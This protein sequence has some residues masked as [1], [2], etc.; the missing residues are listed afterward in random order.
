MHR[1]SEPSAPLVVFLIVMTG[2]SGVLNPSI[3]VLGC[4]YSAFLVLVSTLCTGEASL[5]EV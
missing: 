3:L 4:C 1:L 5:W 2:G